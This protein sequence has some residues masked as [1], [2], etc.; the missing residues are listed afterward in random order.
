MSAI[1]AIEPTE[2]RERLAR[3][4]EL[5]LV[6][7]REAGELAICRIAGALHVPLSELASRHP[8]LDPAR[9]TV[10]I[11]HHGIRSAH[12]AAALAR[13]GFERVLNLSGGIDRWAREVDPTMA[14]Y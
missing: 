1:D 3:G 11:C 7:V 14:R 8:E 6:D 5:V 13:S 9:E 12:A 10:L 2:L 4:D